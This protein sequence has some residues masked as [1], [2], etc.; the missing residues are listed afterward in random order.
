M[1]R[2]DHL[3]AEDFRERMKRNP[4]ERY[5][6]ATPNGEP[7]G[8]RIGRWRKYPLCDNH[9]DRLFDLDPTCETS[10]EGDEGSPE[11]TKKEVYVPGSFRSTWFPIPS[12][13]HYRKKSEASRNQVA[14]CAEVSVDTIKRLE[15]SVCYGWRESV[16]RPEIAERIALAL[17]SLTGRLVT[18]DQLRE[19][20][21]DTE[22]SNE[23][24]VA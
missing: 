16:T 2:A 24:E 4:R 20:P 14:R 11:E 7:C 6:E 1:Y 15:G 19:D 17:T 8:T 13:Y 23:Q 21:P 22:E 3:V 10:L 12:L 18:V 9:D 5:C